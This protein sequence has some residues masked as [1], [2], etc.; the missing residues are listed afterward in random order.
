MAVVMYL[1]TMSLASEVSVRIIG[2]M[3]DVFTY[4]TAARFG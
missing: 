2:E 4:F 3:Y 1:S